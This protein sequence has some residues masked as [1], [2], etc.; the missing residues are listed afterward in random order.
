[1]AELG[2]PAVRWMRR[3]ADADHYQAMMAQYRE[4]YQAWL[5]QVQQYQQ[6]YQQPFPQQYAQPAQAAAPQPFAQPAAAPMSFAPASQPATYSMAPRAAPAVSQ[7]QAPP[8][9]S[10]PAAPHA[11]PY[12]ATTGSGTAGWDEFDKIRSSPDGGFA[13]DALRNNKDAQTEMY[14]DKGDPSSS[15]TNWMRRNSD[16][17]YNRYVS[18]SAQARNPSM[19]FMDW[20]KNANLGAEFLQQSPDNRGYFQGLE[21]PG[22]RWVV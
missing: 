11:N 18:D 20:L 21:N 19:Q 22:A 9:R 6:S 12:G 16:T 8:Y 17:F 10:M 3:K 2:R 15:F 5:Q 4:Q 14:L 1:M 13:Y 7:P